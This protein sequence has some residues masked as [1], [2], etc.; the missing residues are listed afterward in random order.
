MAIHLLSEEL[1]NKIAAGEVIERPASVVKELVENSLDAGATRI[2]VDIRDS[3]KELIRVA[4]NGLGMDE[5]DAK[6]SMLRHCTSKIFQAEDLFSIQTLGF[7]GEAL[8]SIVA[9]S[10]LSLLTRQADA[11]AGFN[12]VVEAGSF[13]SSGTLGAEQGTTVDVRNLF[14]N[15][16]ARK[17][18]LKS[19]A[20]ELRHIV[21]VLAAYALANHRVSFKLSHEG[22][23]LLHSPAAE[24]LQD[25][26][27]SVYGL[28]VAKEMLSVEYED[29]LLSLKGYIAKPYL[30]RNDKTQQ[31]LFVNGRWIRNEDIAKAVYDGYHSTLFVNKHPVFVLAIRL[32]PVA[33]DVNVHPTKAQIKIEQ[34]REVCDAV[35]HAVYSSLQ[36]NNLIPVLDFSAQQTVDDF[37][38]A[39]YSF[40]KSSQRSLEIREESIPMRL[41]EESSE[42]QVPEQEKPT[43]AVRHPSFPPLR[44]LGQVHKT[45]FVAE[46]LGGLYYID[47]HAAHERVL[48]EQFMEQHQ[49]VAVQHLLQ[50]ELMEFSVAERVIIEEHLDTLR[51]LGFILEPFEG[52]T[53]VV[54][55]IPLLFGRLQPKEILYDVLGLLQ[56]GR[57]KIS[58]TKEEIITRMACRAAVMA[59]ETLSVLEMDAILQELATTK[60]PFTCPHGRPTLYKVPFEQLEKIFKR[61]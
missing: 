17:K 8:S 52:N 33:V 58:E 29:E 2:I 9:V 50:P 10:Q 12:L 4:D 44:L 43:E 40:E 42:V 48:Y 18:F 11:L 14:F 20:V 36:K 16:P 59:G 22:H 32:N 26:I 57:Q 27:A 45:F 34:K 24:N 41:N 7:R 47:Q 39:K 13:I 28:G 38:P 23:V 30:A 5:A 15:T 6:A 21:D 37:V 54:K 19:D 49:D 53:Y 46:T 60:L 51:R 61:I 25:T 3:G 1:I 55:T 31:A 35:K 56:E